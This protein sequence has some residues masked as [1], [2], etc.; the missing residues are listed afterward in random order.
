[1]LI[2][3]DYSLTC[4][5]ICLYT[6]VMVCFR[7]LTDTKKYQNNYNMNQFMIE[8]VSHKEWKHP[9]ERYQ[10]IA[11]QI[12]GFEPRL[13]HNVTNINIEDYSMGSKG[14]VFHIAEN[15]AILKAG[16]YNSNKSYNTIPPTVL[17]KFAT[18]KGNAKKEGM[19]EAWLKDTG[20]DLK[21]LFDYEG[22]KCPSPISDI[23]D[24]YYLAK[25]DKPK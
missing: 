24:A 22:E 3:I 19:Y 23:V 4:P 16:L 12:L 11:G 2:G 5:C 25:M 18:G 17:K 8:G 9:I 21:K 20:V 10:N 6:N 7:F 14:K 13:W 15:T 1:M